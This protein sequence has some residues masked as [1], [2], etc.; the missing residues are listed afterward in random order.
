M[1]LANIR[2]WLKTLGVAEHYYTN[3]IDNDKDKCL[4][5]YSR[6]SEGRPV[7]AIGG[8]RNSS[9]DILPISILLH[10]NRSYPEAEAAAQNLWDQLLE[11]TDTD[12]PGG[13]HIQFLQPTVQGPVYVATDPN[14]IHEFVIN[15]NVYYRR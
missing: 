1:T 9:Y 4:G 2:D 13:Q 10:W 15:I 8:I 3:R 6:A 14:G 5:V 12:I 7:I 11:V